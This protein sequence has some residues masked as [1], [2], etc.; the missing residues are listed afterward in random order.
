MTQESEHLDLLI[1]ARAIS[2]FLFGTEEKAKAI[3]PLRKHLGL[4]HLGGKIAGRRG[5]LRERIAA[6][7]AAAAAKAGH[8][9]A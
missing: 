2:I 4:F 6:K 5:T 8:V 1:G 7:E 9:T 3:Y